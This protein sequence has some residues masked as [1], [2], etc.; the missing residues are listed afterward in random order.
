M[1][2][3]FLDSDADLVRKALGGDPLAFESLVQRYQR[4]AFAIA[5]AA[6][7]QASALEDVVQDA[8]LRSF[9]QLP[10]LREPDRFAAMLAPGFG[11]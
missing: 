1:F 2:L 7:T 5:R 9:R 6:G 8:F 11:D 3:S 4:K 10:N